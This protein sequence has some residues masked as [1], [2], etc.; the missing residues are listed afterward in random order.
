MEALEGEGTAGIRGRRRLPNWRIEDPEE[1]RKIGDGEGRK[2][3]R[4]DWELE[5]IGGSEKG[6]GGS[7]R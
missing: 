6:G 2:L 1:L 4:G 3:M 5:E 7:I